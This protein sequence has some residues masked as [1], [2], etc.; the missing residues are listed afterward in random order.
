MSRKK[1]IASALAVMTAFAMIVPCAMS[2]SAVQI[3]T[4]SNTVTDEPTDTEPADTSVDT[5]PTDTGSS[6]QT[7][8]SKTQTKTATKKTTKETEET[9]QTTKETEKTT[10]KTKKTTKKTTTT[11]EEEE[12]TTTE[13]ETTSIHNAA[14]ELSHA[15]FNEDNEVNVK[16]KIDSDGR[17]TKANIYMDF[18]ESILKYKSSKINDEEIG[19]IVSDSCTDGR[20]KFEYTNSS[21]VEYD[22]T[23]VTVTFELKKTTSDQTAVMAVVEDD[24]FLDEDGK[25]FNYSI[26]NAIM[27]I[28][29]AKDDDD[30]SKDSMPDGSE[31]T[32]QP[33]NLTLGDK[34]MKLESL[35]ITDYKSVVTDN[36]AIASVSDGII[37]M[38]AAGECKM[39]VVYKDGAK[40]YYSLRIADVAG[41]GPAVTD[42]SSD[43]SSGAAASI[44][45]SSSDNKT[46]KIT[47]IIVIVC[48]ALILLIAEYFILVAHRRRKEKNKNRRDYED[49]DDDDY[50]YHTQMMSTGDEDMKTFSPRPERRLEFTEEPQVQPV[51]DFEDFLR[52]DSR[53]E[54]DFTG[55]ITKVLDKGVVRTTRENTDDIRPDI[56]DFTLSNN[57]F[58]NR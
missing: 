12:T 37:I 51:N 44:D 24:N 21:G 18:D 3:G 46:L 41:D 34:E 20:Y 38:H 19:G 10:K 25:K 14:V 45:D 43:G 8:P 50:D 52:N 47:V 17:I 30:S 9:E 5:E 56:E 13:D 39:T 42:E 27:T 6:K 4:E 49:D 54:L 22:G 1:L 11:T 55:P 2:V 31:R 15:G 23:F 33:I 29:D 16:L 28:P 35:G 48:A 53:E 57:N 26:S 7:Q 58:S 32:Y 40:G 36:D